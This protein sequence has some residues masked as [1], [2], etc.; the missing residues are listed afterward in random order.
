[1][2][3]QT[4]L[5]TTNVDTVGQVVI[6]DIV[7]PDPITSLYT[8]QIRVYDNSTPAVLQFTLQLTGA[9]KASIEL[10]APAALF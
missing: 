8:R 1:M 3:I 2:S 6:T 5:Q 10:T 9:T 4:I 7:G